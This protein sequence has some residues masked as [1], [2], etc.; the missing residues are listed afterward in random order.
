MIPAWCSTG[1]YTEYYMVIK[2]TR[3]IL[4]RAQPRA[5][6]GPAEREDRGIAV[7]RPLS[8]YC[9]SFPDGVVMMLEEKGHDEW[10]DKEDADFGL[11]RFF[12]SRPSRDRGE[13]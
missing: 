6:R 13:H 10:H 9:K 3:S 4:S 5:A 8:Y 1:M 11:E 12:R 7:P 2:L